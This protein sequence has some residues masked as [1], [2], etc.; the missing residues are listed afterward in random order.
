MQK[1]NRSRDR[2][3][4]LSRKDIKLLD[5][6]LRDGGYLNDWEFGK[7]N[8]INIFE[9]LVGAGVDIIETGFLDERRR[10]FNREHVDSLKAYRELVSEEMPA[11]FVLIDRA[12]SAGKA[13]GFLENGDIAVITAGV[14]IGRSGTTNMLKVQLVD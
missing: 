10:L 13:R 4:D 7:S 8:I 12:I 5:C 14:P 6:T 1:R 2:R 11:V 9:R 3:K